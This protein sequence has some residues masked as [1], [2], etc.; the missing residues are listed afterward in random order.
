NDSLRIFVELAGGGHDSLNAL[1]RGK[2]VAPFS[3]SVRAFVPGNPREARVRFAPDGRIIGFDRK[4]ADADRRPSLSVDSGQRV[5]RT[6]LDKWIDE[7]AERWKLVTSSYEVKKASGR[8]DRTYT[9]ERIDRR[10]GGAPIRAEVTIAGDL[11]AR[12][13]PY[14]EIPESFRRRYA[15]MRSWNM[16]IA[17]L[18][19]FGFLGIAIIGI[20]MLTRFSRQRSVRWREPMVVGAVIGGLTLAAGIN[21][22]S[23][24]WFSYDTA[25]APGTFAATQ[26]LLAL[27]LGATTALTAAFTL[28]AAEA[29]TRHAFPRHLDWWK[30]WRY[31]GTREVAAQ[32][33][34]GYAVAMI[35]FAYVALFY[36]VTRTLFGWWVPS[37]LLDD[38]NQIASPMPWISGIALSL[39]AGVWEESLFRALPLSLLSLWVGQRPRRRWW[40]AGGVVVSALIF[41]FA[42]ATYESWPPYSRG[43]ELFLEASFWAILFLNFGILVT[44]VAHFVFDLVLFGIFAGAG[45]SIEYRVTAAIILLALLSPAIAVVWRWV[46]QRGLTPAPEDARFEAWTA[47]AEDEPEVPIILSLPVVFTRRAR[48]LAI[49]AAVAGVVVAVALPPNPP[50]GPQFTADRQRVIATADSMLLARGGN[51][52]AWRRLTGIGTDTL[53][54]WPRFLRQHKLVPLAQWFA[55]KY[56]PATWWTVRYVRPSGSEAQRVEEWRFRVWPDGRPLDARHLVSDGAQRATADSTGLRRI[57]L[58]ALASEGIDTSKLQETEVKRTAKMS[59]YDATVTYT[60]TSV[61]LPDGAAARAWVQIAGDEPLVARRGMEL[62]EEFLRADRTIQTNRMLIAAVGGLLLLGLVVAGA[63]LVKRRRPILVN[64]GTLN[65]RQTLIFVGVVFVLTSL[66]NLNSLPSELF[67]YDTAQS[68]GNF[69]ATTSLAFLLG[70]PLALLVLGEWLALGALRRRVGIPMLAAAPSR[71]ASNEMLIAGLA[72]GGI[73]FAVTHLDSLLPR[74]GMPR[75]PTTILNEAFPAL[76]GITSIPTRALMTVAVIAIPLL[77]VG[78]LTRRW[79]LRALCAA[80]L[81]GLVGLVV[82]SMAPPSELGPAV[83]AI[84]V[85]AIVAIVSIAL[86]V[87]GPRSA[88][89]WVVAVLTVMGLGGLRDAV[90]GP[91]WQVRANGLLVVLV[92][93]GVIALIV[94]LTSAARAESRPS[95]DILTAAS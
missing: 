49:A 92:V 40:M 35:G 13:R 78:G 29:A 54:A 85:I 62:P 88:W 74:T 60:D 41:G 81:L 82:W 51:P 71:S 94:H 65:R 50:L 87:W 90:Y 26:V 69:I 2:D 3:W 58:A 10:I 95:D 57:A 67:G 46:Q 17:A 7:G 24:N 23:G 27:L 47:T 68:W 38:P 59:R 5:A 12:V 37:E 8:I 64:D 80:V 33:G 14:V 11:P 56:E 25:M 52:A 76:A 79:Y 89:S 1:I 21:E 34:G 61:K 44:V 19:T 93:S 4:L 32:V 86:V 84:M 42:H 43:V 70:I 15:E 48:W 39:N 18:A 9:F 31:R 75:A 63:I 30:L 53:A 16:L 20:V 22:M 45:S 28:A 36:L 77:V 72:L 83:G 55:S 73:A 66:S 6:L 91:V